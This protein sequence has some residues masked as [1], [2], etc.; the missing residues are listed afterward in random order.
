M[1]ADA[2]RLRTISAR[3][4]LISPIHTIMEERIAERKHNCIYVTLTTLLS[5]GRAGR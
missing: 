5:H 1:V 2:T 3:E 4:L